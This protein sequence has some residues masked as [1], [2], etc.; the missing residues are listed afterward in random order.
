[1]LDYS[2]IPCANLE[3]HFLSQVWPI[4]IKLL[5]QH[6]QEPDI[7]LYPEQFH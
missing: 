3:S 1:M 7:F 6:D 4:S 2:D 5:A